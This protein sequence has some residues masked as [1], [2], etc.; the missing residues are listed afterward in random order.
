[1]SIEFDT[2]AN[3]VIAQLQPKN[4][5]RIDPTLPDLTW[6]RQLSI[7]GRLTYD[8]KITTAGDDLDLI[9]PVGTTQFVY[10]VYVSNSGGTGGAFQIFNTDTERLR[11]VFPA[12][13]TGVFPTKE[14]PFFDS[15]VGDS[16]KTLSFRASAG[17]MRITILGWVENTSRIRDAAI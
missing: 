6:L 4:K 14:I 13:G 12:A 2:P 9:P 16:I 7:Q 10:K 17:S 8:F 15:L 11:I 3:R 1:M 5:F